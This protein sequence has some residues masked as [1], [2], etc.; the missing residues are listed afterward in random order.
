M[1]NCLAC[2]RRQV[3]N[4]TVDKSRFSFSRRLDP[5]DKT[6]M[7]AF[8]N[9]DLREFPKQ[10]EVVAKK[11]RVLDATG[12]KITVIPDYVEL[13]VTCNR[14]GLSKNR[15]AEVPRGISNLTNLR[16]LLLDN[17]R[18]RTLPKAV[19]DLPKLERLNL[20]HNYLMELPRSIRKLKSLKYLDICNN[21]LVSLP[22]ELG[23][24][25]SLEELHASS[26]A[27][28]RLPVDL[29]KLERLRLII[30]E[31]NTIDSVP[32][33]VLL[34]CENLQTI[35]LHGNPITLE[36]LQETKGYSEFEARR[37]AKWDKSLAAGVLLGA[38]RF[39]EGF[40]RA[41]VS[42]P[43]ARQK[44][45]TPFALDPSP[46]PSP[47]GDSSQQLLDKKQRSSHTGLKNRKNKKST[48]QAHE[49]SIDASSSQN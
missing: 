23:E 11:V 33:E 40:D 21:K 6:G 9:S 48:V 10:V 45:P 49:L 46:S 20:A 8:R 30:A 42:S 14:M 12:N 38:S 17:N 34:Y 25:Q 2:D 36:K 24:L 35:A 47:S 15:I 22:R 41:I 13:M 32:S 3:D 5:W 43:T 19:F 31:S 39:D 29:A 37:K 28:A 27:L 1:G 7:V 44:K 18:I 26:N 16:V 4:L